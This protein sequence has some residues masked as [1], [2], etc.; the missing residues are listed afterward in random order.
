M[1][2]RAQEGKRVA[3]QGRPRLDAVGR[4][5]GHTECFGAGGDFI[6]V[7]EIS[8]TAAGKTQG[9][10]GEGFQGFPG[11][12]NS[13]RRPPSGRSGENRDQGGQPGVGP[14]STSGLDEVR[15][16]QT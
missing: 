16:R 9:Q 4:P 13:L 11:Y 2:F 7:P 8:N 6:T 5:G 15:E 3:G 10:E 14:D 1:S 12:S